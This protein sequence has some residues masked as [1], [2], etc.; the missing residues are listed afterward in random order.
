MALLNGITTG[1]SE[2]FETG[3]QGLGTAIGLPGRGGVLTGLTNMVDTG[4]DAALGGIPTFGAP[5][6]NFSPLP[7][8]I[9]EYH[10]YNTDASK[11]PPNSGKLR[12]SPAGI[13][14]SVGLDE[15]TNPDNKYNV[16]IK[17]A[18][19]RL[20]T[21]LEERSY[22]DFYFPGEGLQSGQVRRVAFFENPMIR[23]SR[24]PRY[25]ELPIV[26]RN[27]PVR[28]FV[29]ANPRKVKLEFT[30]T[31]P[32]VEH[33]FHL[34]K[35][36]LYGLKGFYKTDLVEKP[37]VPTMVF[38]GGDLEGIGSIVG[39][40]E[41]ETV[42]KDW[43]TG[44]IGQFFGLGFKTDF[45][46]KVSLQNTDRGAG[47][48]FYEP[49][50]LEPKD[51][52]AEAKSSTYL[53]RLLRSWSL[54]SEDMESMGMVATLYTQFVIDTIRASVIGDNLSLGQVGPPLVRFRHGTIF[55]EAPFIV[56]SF[57]INYLN[58]KGYE[59][60]TL[61]P[62]QIKF[63]LSLEEF[64][65]QHGAQHGGSQEQVPGASDILNLSTG[66]FRGDERHTFPKL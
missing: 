58:D 1:I 26:T 30:Y 31:L 50:L 65:Q 34:M 4:L 52:I 61:T 36:A 24:S 57:D 49:T 35:S 22:L 13:G 41:A 63:S 64:R 12:V 66:F 51:G 7:K 48:R 59:V 53:E 40:T 56:K 28:L 18:D 11:V 37:L 14:Q 46:D 15:D 54:D 25:A 3:F 39:L 6:N 62:R 47:P 8:G 19:K 45:S 2:I 16:V 21:V 38:E 23:E 20:N 27:E 43:A 17:E 55:N 33:F 42:Y 9:H 5:P 10:L 32:H 60:R 29:G 44:K